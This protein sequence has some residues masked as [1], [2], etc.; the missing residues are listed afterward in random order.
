MALENSELQTQTTAGRK[1]LGELMANGSCS[2]RSS[3]GR[4]HESLNAIVARA[5]SS[6]TARSI[7][8]KRAIAAF[9]TDLAHYENVLSFTKSES[10]PPYL[11]GRKR[12]HAASPHNLRC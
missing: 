1:G 8:R 2:S 7:P 9:W 6:P 3:P 4:S 10:M 5:G 12:V 11:D